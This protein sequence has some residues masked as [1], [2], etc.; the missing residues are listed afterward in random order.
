VQEEGAGAKEQAAVCLLLAEARRT[1]NNLTRVIFMITFYDNFP[2]EPDK[3]GW[4]DIE[5]IYCF[6][7][8]RFDGPLMESLR[9]IFAKLPGSV[10]HD[11]HDCHWWYADREDIENGY[12]TAGVEPP[13]LMVFGSLKLEVWREWEQ[14]FHR[15]IEITGVLPF[16]TL[17]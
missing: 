17:Q 1:R 15:S 2:L 5:R 14:A 9:T 4:L 11:P 13:G 6:D 7:W 10:L 12:L 16:R 8:D 3:D